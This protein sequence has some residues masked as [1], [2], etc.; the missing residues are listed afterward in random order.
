MA[1]LELDAKGISVQRGLCDEALC[2]A[3]LEEIYSQ[4]ESTLTLPQS[5][6]ES[7]R[8]FHG[9]HFLK[10]STSASND[11]DNAQRATH[12]HEVVLRRS[13]HVTA[14]LRAALSGATSGAG[15]AL[16][17][18]LGPSAEL[19]ELTAIVSEPGAAAQPLHSDGSWSSES[20]PRLITLFL[21]LHDIADPAM[22]PTT[23]CESTHMPHCFPGGRWLPPSKALADERGYVWHKLNAGDGILMDQMT[24][25]RGGANTSEVRRTLLSLSFV[26]NAEGRRESG[27]QVQLCDFQDEIEVTAAVG[28]APVQQ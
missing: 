15:A 9:R 26:E 14:L 6:A 21:A 23:F 8:P 20:A 17:G 28:T 5:M 13:Q 25:H 3:C 1:H 24:W 22:G 11:D 10:F 2:A 18:L 16:R 27:H 12:R 4:L 19:C 7:M